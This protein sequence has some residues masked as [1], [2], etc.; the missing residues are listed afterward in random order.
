MA[1]KTLDE[2]TVLT[3]ETVNKIVEDVYAALDKGKYRV[4]PNP[5]KRTEPLKLSPHQRTELLTAI[6]ILT[7]NRHE[8]SRTEEL[9]KRKFVFFRVVRG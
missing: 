7:T 5:H 6:L 4:L 8:P 1:D 2:D 3:D 9:S